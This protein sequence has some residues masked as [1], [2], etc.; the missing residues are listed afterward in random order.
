MLLKMMSLAILLSTVAAGAAYAGTQGAAA[1]VSL[2]QPCTVFICTAGI[3]FCR[4]ITK[5]IP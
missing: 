5:R 2:P 1:A 4:Y 3:V